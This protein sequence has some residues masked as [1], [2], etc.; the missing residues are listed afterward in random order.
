MGNIKGNDGAKGDKGDKGDFGK[1]G[2]SVLLGEGEPSDTS[3]SHA[4]DYVFKGWDKSLDNVRRDT[5]FTAIFD[6]PNAFECKFLNS[7]GSLLGTSYCS[8][9]GT[10]VF[11][12]DTPMKPDESDGSGTITRYEF[13]GWDKSLKNIDDER[14]FIAQYGSTTYYECRFVNYDGTLLYTSDTFKGGAVDYE[15]G[16]SHIKSKTQMAPKSQTMFFGLE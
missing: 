15:G 1:S 3:G 10:A 9:G 12:G 16:E 11:S 7:D 14:T 6:A 4:I 8:V 13:S 5:V 2:A